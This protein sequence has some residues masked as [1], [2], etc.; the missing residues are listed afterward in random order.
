M[1]RSIHHIALMVSVMCLVIPTVKSEPLSGK[2]L[3]D[4]ACEASIMGA[5]PQAI[6]RPL[7]A[8]YG[9]DTRQ[10]RGHRPAGH[11]HL[12]GATLAARGVAW[13]AREPRPRTRTCM[14]SSVWSDWV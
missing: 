8:P 13:R 12:R 10:E 1:T 5:I 7:V 9:R 11:R 2:Q 14:E 6:L 3:Y 4:I